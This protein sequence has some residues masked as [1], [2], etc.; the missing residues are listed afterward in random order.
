MSKK[1]KK[2]RYQRKMERRNMFKN[3]TAPLA[4][5]YKLARKKK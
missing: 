3:L 4:G 5:W 1:L 2:S